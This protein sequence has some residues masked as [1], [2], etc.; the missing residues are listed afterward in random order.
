[1]IVVQ[2]ISVLVVAFVAVQQLT[3]VRAQ[4]C[5][6]DPDYDLSSTTNDVHPNA[7]CPDGSIIKEN[8]GSATCALSDCTDDECCDH[9]PTC[10]NLDGEGQEYACP[11][12]NV[13]RSDHATRTCAEYQCRNTYSSYCPCQDFDCCQL[14]PRCHDGESAYSC[15][16]G[17]A[18]KSNPDPESISCVAA[19]CT[20]TECCDFTS[21][22]CGNTDGLGNGHGCETGVLKGSYSSITCT[23]G[24]CTDDECCDPI[25]SCFSFNFEQSSC[26]VGTTVKSTLPTTPCADSSCTSSEC[27]DANPSCSSSSFQQS[28]CDAGFTV[29]ASLPTSNCADSSCTS[30][31]CCEAFDCTAATCTSPSVATVNLE[32]TGCD[33]VCPAG[34]TCLPTC[35]DTNSDGVADD[36]F[37]CNPGGGYYGLL[38]PVLTSTCTADPCTEVECCNP[39]PLTCADTNQDGTTDDAFSCGVG[40]LVAKNPVPTTECASNPC[41]AAECAVFVYAQHSCGC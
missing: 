32:N 20:D 4:T 30:S 13:L 8:S 37:T 15:G 19:F 38:D 14:A 27:C 23:S 28:S 35:A 12:S 29:K 5:D 16:V 22:T 6:Q 40:S 33:C 25:P 24:S 41:G 36:W 31:E 1:M 2:H 39:N 26:N 34:Q 9:K 17:Y 21:P 10:D 7:R 11:A 3:V 18:L